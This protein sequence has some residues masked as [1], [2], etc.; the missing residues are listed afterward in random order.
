MVQRLATKSASPA[1]TAAAKATTATSDAT[2]SSRSNTWLS[3]ATAGR[4]LG[5]RLPI[6]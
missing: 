6:T 5:G 2:K 4:F 3:N 1:A